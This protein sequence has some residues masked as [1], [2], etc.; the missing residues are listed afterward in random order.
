MIR[1]KKNGKPQKITGYNDRFRIESVI[2]LTIIILFSSVHVVRETYSGPP[3]LTFIDRFT[4]GVLSI[5]VLILKD[6][7][8]ESPCKVENLQKGFLS[9]F[10][11][12]VRIL[13]ELGSGFP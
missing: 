3:S 13:K 9:H 8:F 2:F 12:D 1:Q 4:S 6:L 5:A 7:S 10:C 11:W